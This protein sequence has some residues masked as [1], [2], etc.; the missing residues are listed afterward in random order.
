M[1]ESE[2]KMERSHRDVARGSP[3][4]RQAFHKDLTLPCMQRNLI[5]ARSPTEGSLGPVPTLDKS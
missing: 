4:G 1:E 3:M 5:G 2:A